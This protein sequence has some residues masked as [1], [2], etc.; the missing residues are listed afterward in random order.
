MLQFCLQAL[1][2]LVVLYSFDW[3]LANE[4]E[5]WPKE[6][7]KHSRNYPIEGHANQFVGREQLEIYKEKKWEVRKWRDCNL[8]M[9]IKIPYNSGILRVWVNGETHGRVKDRVTH[10]SKELLKKLSHWRPCQSICG[11]RT[12]GNLKRKK[13]EVRRWRDCNLLMTIKIPYNSGI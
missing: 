7:L 8:S 6:Q 11:E 13:W 12:I 5:S 3:V 4:L 2:S 1:E 10:E 9:N